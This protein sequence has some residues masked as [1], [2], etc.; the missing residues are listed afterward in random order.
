[1]VLNGTHLFTISY[2]FF[3]VV[4]NMHCGFRKK[5]RSHFFPFEYLHMLFFCF[6][7]DVSMVLHKNGGAHLVSFWMHMV[8]CFTQREFLCHASHTVSFNY[9][10]NICL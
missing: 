10:C 8:F 4:L 1:M 2:S 7:L 9:S 3:F 6:S 5:K